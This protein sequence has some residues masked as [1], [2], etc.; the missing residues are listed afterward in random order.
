MIDQESITWAVGILFSLGTLFLGYKQ[1]AKA[2]AKGAQE[3]TA[4]NHKANL[5]AQSDFQDRLLA[6]IDTQDRHISTLHSE[7]AAAKRDAEE[8]RRSQARAERHFDDCER[9]LA[10]IKEQLSRC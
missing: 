5:Q 2:A 1:I 8:A 4:E 7:V 3:L 6:R 9:E 10:A